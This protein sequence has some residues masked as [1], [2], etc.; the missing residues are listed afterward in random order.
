M[1]DSIKKHR[2][3]VAELF[4]GVGGFRVGL[5]RT[6]HWQVVWSNQWEPP[7]TESKQFAS[8][9]Y[10]RRFGRKQGTVHL[11]ENLSK[12]I[13]LAESG[14]LQ[15]PSVDL[16]VG[17]FP[18][19]DYSVAKPLRQAKGL[20]GM[21]GELWWDI[22]R[23]LLVL[24]KQGTIPQFLLF[25]N[26]DRLLRSP[27]GARGRDFATILL[28]L[29]RLG[30]EVE[31]RVINAADYGMAQ[32]RRRVFIVAMR[33]GILLSSG[34]DRIRDGVLARAF[35]CRLED[36]SE[37]GTL[38]PDQSLNKALLD[39]PGRW[40]FRNAGFMRDAQVWSRRVIPTGRKATPLSRILLRDSAIPEGYFIKGRQKKKKWIYLKGA[41]TE[42]RTHSESGHVYKYAEGALS[43]PD[44]TGLPARTILT[45]EGGS[46]PSRS[47]HVVRASDGRLRR[48]VPEELEKLMGFRPGW[49]A[50]CGM[51]DV[52][53]AFC[54]GNAV[55][56]GVI[57]RIGAEL[58][59]IAK[60]SDVHTMELSHEQT[61]VSA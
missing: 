4:A 31:W 26:V 28:S 43:Y 56:V 30:Y 39:D 8:R 42:S 11:N 54:M 12:V 51:S 44:D 6:G 2:L 41:K 23:F 25:E 48:L 22:E 3:R 15:L 53:R 24:E 46:A 34:V 61:A 14:E 21:K 49:T 9:C 10:V 57:R 5:E 7:G 19:Q 17:G 13:S 58:G 59:A 27:H 18:C 52:Q 45:S 1:T 20:E 29:A 40:S 38:V 35:R 33:S 36:D 16:V 55:V 47:K 60:A 50:G 37:V 32:R